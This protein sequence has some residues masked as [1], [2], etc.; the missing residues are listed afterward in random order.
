[1]YTFMNLRATEMPFSERL[2]ARMKEL[3]IRAIDIHKRL[4]VTKGTVSQWVNGIAQPRG[5]NASELAAMLRCSVNWL[6]TGKGKPEV[7]AELEPGPPITGQVPMISWIQAG[8]W[9][10][11]AEEAKDFTT[12]YATTAK[13]GPQAFALRVIG[14]S[15]TSYTGGKSIPEGSLVIVDPD[16][17]AE[18][19][20]VVVARLDDSNEATLK[21]LVIDGGKKYLKP[22]NINYPVKEI[23]GN[24]TIIGVVK[25]VVQE[26]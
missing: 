9:L 21:Q 13:V 8:S 17:A 12:F 3:N 18:N 1:M 14:D 25:Q 23:N 11:M 10:E 22:F 2:Q 7:G 15:M 5:G 19:G 4:G 20:K 24:C 6:M 26:F 16:I